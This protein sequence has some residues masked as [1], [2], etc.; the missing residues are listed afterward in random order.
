MGTTHIRYLKK[1]HGENISGMAENS[2]YWF[3]K[4]SRPVFDELDR[5][6]EEEEAIRRDALLPPIQKGCWNCNNRIRPRHNHR[7]CP[8]DYK[9]LYC[10]ICGLHGF[11]RWTCPR[12]SCKAKRGSQ[13]DQPV[14]EVP[15]NLTPQRFPRV[16]LPRYND[17]QA[18][19]VPEPSEL[20]APTLANRLRLRRKAL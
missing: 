8:A 2:R 17:H 1:F 19:V 14:H 13:G 15:S 7:D 18:E 9:Q 11:D 4:S 16:R 5:R 10:Y 6:D 20:L 12:L 3:T